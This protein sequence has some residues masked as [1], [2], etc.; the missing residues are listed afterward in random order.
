VFAA[1]LHQSAPTGWVSMITATRLEAA[2][3][4]DLWRRAQVRDRLVA[5]CKTNFP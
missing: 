4:S 3:G 2:I 5:Q 1:W